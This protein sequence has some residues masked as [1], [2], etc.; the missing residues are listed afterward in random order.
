MGCYI[1]TLGIDKAEWLAIAG[2]PI[3]SAEEAKITEL[4]LPVCL[5]DNGMF[6]AAGVA[7]SYSELDQFSRSGDSRPKTWFMVPRVELYDV[8]DLKNY[9]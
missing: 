8:S 4:E 6:K 3:A 9:E 7:Y 2:R 5:V 1:N